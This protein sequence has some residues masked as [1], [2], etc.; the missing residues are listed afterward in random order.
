VSK[1][2]PGLERFGIGKAAEEFAITWEQ[3]RP[4]GADLSDLIATIE[5]QR[6]QPECGYDFT[7]YSGHGH[8]WYIEVISVGQSHLKSYRFF[9]SAN[10]RSVFKAAEF[11]LLAMYARIGLG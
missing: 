1:S 3:R 11:R 10:E 8:P 4:E 7:S 5:N 6:E 2:E 9:P